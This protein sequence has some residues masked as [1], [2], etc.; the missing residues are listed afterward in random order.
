MMNNKNKIL[1]FI[2]CFFLLYLSSP[3][4]AQENNNSRLRKTEIKWKEVKGASGYRVQVALK[5]K[6]VVFDKVVL[7]NKIVFSLPSGIYYIK[8]GALNKFQKVA[9]WS[10]WSLFN[11]SSPS[12]FAK[13][14]QKK[15]ISINLEK[16]KT[17]NMF[18][19]NRG[20][21]DI[22][23][24][25]DLGYTINQ[26]LPQWN[27]VVENS[28]AGDSLNVSYC[29]GNN[30]TIRKIPVLRNMGIE[31][32]FNFASYS[33][34]PSASFPLVSLNTFRFGTNIFY[35]TS[36]NSPANI[37]V[38]AGG[39]MVVSGV[40]LN[41]YDSSSGNTTYRDLTSFDGYIDLGVFVEFRFCDFFHI[42]AGLEF[43]TI[44]YKQ[45]S[46]LDLKY[47]ISFGVRI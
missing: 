45:Q 47:K 11:V 37:I 35:T 43:N 7:L 3:L 25:I 29:L 23:I 41:L 21:A 6:S 19:E 18:F 17:P 27:S 4:F 39:G 22:G 33:A 10:G 36:F 31:G 40:G 28:F 38:R 30:F 1:L 16:K 42:E 24:K 46:L 9:V 13:K 44:F 26:I 14:K 8:I 2:L 32:N 12:K 34:I 5:D 15:E 20:F